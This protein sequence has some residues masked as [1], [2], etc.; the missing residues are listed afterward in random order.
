MNAAAIAIGSNS[1][2]LLVRLD[3][4][5]EHRGRE[6]TRLFLGLDNGKDLTETAMNN[7]AQ[8]VLRLKNIACAMGAENVLL[9]ATSAVRDAGNSLEFARRLFETS[10]LRLRVISGLEEA[11]LAFEAASRGR[12][13]A[14]LDIGGGSSEL[15]YG[16]ANHLLDAVSAQEGASRLFRREGPIQSWEDAERALSA[17]RGRLKAASARLLELP[18][19]ELLVAIVGTAATLA[20]VTQGVHSHGEELEGTQ[21]TL[22]ETYA[23]LQRVAPMT[24]EARAGIPGLYASR[25]AI[26]PHGLC[27]LIAAMELTGFPALTVS[28]HNNLDAV[29]TRMRAGL[30]PPG[31]EG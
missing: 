10:G 8:A 24:P 19:P 31:R 16:S 20:A 5:R 2:R 6:D 27:I 22:G 9:C 23:L 17:V 15:T 4:G 28:V 11:E 14:V 29:V 21:V 18:R 1:T 3:N 26:I 13:C 30:H 7:T 25:A 12:D